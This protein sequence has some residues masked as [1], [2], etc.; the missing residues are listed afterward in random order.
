MPSNNLKKKPEN[1]TNKTFLINI[2]TQI[3][4]TKFWVVEFA[5]GGLGG[6]RNSSEIVGTEKGKKFTWIWVS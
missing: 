3:R 5:G 1:T 6:E 4:W 2:G